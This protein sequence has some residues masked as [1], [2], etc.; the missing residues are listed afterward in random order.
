MKNESVLVA[1]FVAALYSPGERFFAQAWLQGSFD[2]TGNPVFTDFDG[3]GPGRGRPAPRPGPHPGRPPGRVLDLPAVVRARASAASPRSSSCT[4]TRRSRTP[5]GAGPA[6]HDH[7]D[8][9]QAVRRGERLGRDDGPVRV[10]HDGDGRPRR[11]AP[12]GGGPVLRLP[13]RRPGELVLRADRPGPRDGRRDRGPARSVAGP[14][15]RASIPPALPTVTQTGAM[16]DA[17]D[18]DAGDGR[19]GGPTGRSGAGTTFTPGLLRGRGGAQ[20]VPGASPASRRSPGTTGR[21]RPTATARGCRTGSTS[22]T[23][24]SATWSPRP[25]RRASRPSG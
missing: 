3:V 7:R 24:G 23:T 14:R 17:A 19:D 15:P 25:T 12:G 5:P 4:T 10:E 20:R 16:D 13:V 22:G 1:P 9:E 18:A 2:L 6:V 21:S 8:H 11:P